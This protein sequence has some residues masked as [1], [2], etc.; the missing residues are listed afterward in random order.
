[1]RVS[2]RCIPRFQP[3]GPALTRSLARGAVEML[4]Q[5]R[6]ATLVN[7]QTSMAQVRD[8]KSHRLIPKVRCPRPLPCRRQGAR[9]PA[10]RLSRPDRPT[11]RPMAS[12]AC[13]SWCAARLSSCGSSPS[14]RRRRRPGRRSRQRGR[15][16]RKPRPWLRGRRCTERR[17]VLGTGDGVGAM[18]PAHGPLSQLGGTA[19]VRIAP[20]QP[21]PAVCGL[22]TLFFTKASPPPAHSASA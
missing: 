7:V 10:T 1:M 8:S 22:A 13:R 18:W 16:C 17:V 5:S 12:R 20:P 11:A 15:P 4:K 3:P 19:C 21:P 14:W 6:V 9:F 2:A